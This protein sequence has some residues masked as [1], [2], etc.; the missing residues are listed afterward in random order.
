[1]DI[2]FECEKCGQLLV[3]EEA[4][5][6]ISIPCPSCS[7]NLIVPVADK[8]ADTPASDFFSQT[9]EL[10]MPSLKPLSVCCSHREQIFPKLVLMYG[11]T[12]PVLAERF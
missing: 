6:G 8:T 7:A 5:A 9:R 1:M 4:G 2:R 3:I 12:V 10:K 11:I